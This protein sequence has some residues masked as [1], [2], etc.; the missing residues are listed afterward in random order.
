MWVRHSAGVA[1]INSSVS[2]HE[3]TGGDNGG[4]GRDGRIVWQAFEQEAKITKEARDPSAAGAGRG[5]VG[6]QSA[7]RAD[8]GIWRGA[9]VGGGQAG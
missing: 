2:D 3:G 8:V 4:K 9:R 5:R 7:R 6:E 1:K